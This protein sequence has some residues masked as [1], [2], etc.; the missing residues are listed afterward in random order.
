[1][2]QLIIFFSSFF[3]TLLVTP[4]L[5]RFLVKYDILDKPESRRINYINIPRMG[6]LVLILVNSVILL[7]AFNDLNSL[8]FVIIGMTILI[9]TGII[10]D[11]KQ[12]NYKSKLLF[13]TLASLFLIFHFLP[14]INSYSIGSFILPDIG[15]LIIL[16]LI[17]MG[18][19]N[20]LNMMDG[21]D[22]LF[23][24]VSL[25]IF[26]VLF[27]VS[28]NIGNAFVQLFSITLLGSL[29]AFLKFNSYPAKIFLGDTGSSFLAIT[30]IINTFDLII[31][32]YGGNI[33][34]LIPIL[35]F[36]LPL[37]DTLKVIIYRILTGKSPFQA[38]KLH[39]HHFLIELNIKHRT[40]VFIIQLLFVPFIILAII[41]FRNPDSYYLLLF[42]PLAVIILFSK[43]IAGII[44]TKTKIVRIYSGIKNLLHKAFVLFDKLFLLVLLFTPPVIILSI[45]PIRIFIESEIPLLLLVIIILMLLVAFSHTR[46]LDSKRHFYVFLNYFLFFFIINTKFMGYAEFTMRTLIESRTVY[47]IGLFSLIGI[48]LY[49]MILRDR[50]IPVDRDFFSGIELTIIPINLLT[51]ILS[52]VFYKEIFL[53]LS[54]SIMLS[55]VIYISYKI[56]IVTRRKFIF[57][58]FY[59]SFLPLFL[60]IISL[61]L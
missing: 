18:L 56:F 24:S 6:G 39:L 42:I 59:G 19:I 47:H 48:V 36:G 2:L 35:L 8:R 28:Y 51:F 11:L 58:L 33:D 22:G 34:L 46:I 37:I 7:V 31:K 27:I 57:I 12:I 3:L 29:L 49:F 52:N 10:D 15:G 40:V 23:T 43:D 55:F 25:M 61:F 38:D 4:Y 5:I 17:I 13:Q 26:L 30:L 50:L 60:L 9:A 44:I 54:I 32:R 16:L 20:S 14:S 21:V 1:M 53:P 45:I 41:Y